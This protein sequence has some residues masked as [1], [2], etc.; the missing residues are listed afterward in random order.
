MNVLHHKLFPRIFVLY[1]HKAT[2]LFEWEP[3]LLQAIELVV[4]IQ[5]TMKKTLYYTQ[6]THAYILTPKASPTHCFY[7]TI[8]NLK[9]IHPQPY[10]QQ[11]VSQHE[12]VREP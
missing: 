9:P 2:V 1:C 10:M 4:H 11:N 8:R 3:A 12:L 5:Y 7:N 6:K